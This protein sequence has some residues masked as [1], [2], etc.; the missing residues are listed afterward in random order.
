MDK[1]KV[2]LPAPCGAGAGWL[3]QYAGHTLAH[4]RF[5]QDPLNNMQLSCNRLQFIH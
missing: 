5:L 1:Q 4:A 3:N 2:S